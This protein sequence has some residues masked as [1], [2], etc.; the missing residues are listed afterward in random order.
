MNSL[1]KRM[2]PIV[3]AF[4]NGHITYKEARVT[5]YV[6]ANW[7]GELARALYDIEGIQSWRSFNEK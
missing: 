2:M 5:A 7:Y 4:G 3:D 6:T 1:S